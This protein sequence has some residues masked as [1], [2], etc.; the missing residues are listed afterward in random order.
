VIKRI[1]SGGQ[2]GAD[3]G[4]L[5]AGQQLEIPT[6]GWAP[7]NWMTEDGPAPWLADFGLSE[8]STPG[9]AY[10]THLNA[11]DADATILLGDEHSPG[12]ALTKR[13]C[14]RHFRPC[15]VNP[16]MNELRALIRGEGWE[17]LNIAGNR[18]SKNP[19]LFIVT[20]DLLMYALA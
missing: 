20:V 8:C 15:S 2:T 5:I 11:H 9:Y 14:D 4:G 6:G 10:R 12:S 16:S 18:E 7:K 19:G 17:V 3:Q 1:I 13:A